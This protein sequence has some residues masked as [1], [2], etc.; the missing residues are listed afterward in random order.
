[1][2]LFSYPHDYR[3]ND[4]W[5]MLGASVEGW[6]VRNWK[7]ASH[8]TER[9]RTAP[10]T[11]ENMGKCMC[12]CTCTHTL[13]VVVQYSQGIYV[14]ML[15]FTIFVSSFSGTTMA[16]SLTT[17]QKMPSL[18]LRMAASSGDL[19]SFRLTFASEV[20]G[21]FAK[22]VT[23]ILVSDL[24]SIADHIFLLHQQH[25]VSSL[26]KWQQDFNTI[27]KPLPHVFPCHY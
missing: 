21:N 9:L 6:P 13:S 26:I 7:S 11:L 22:P 2:T 27:Y 1:M 12:V 19:M 25:E 8:C 14:H 10:C 4:G 16:L 15:T 18:P 20:G 24:L 3:R 17:T 5:F 23:L